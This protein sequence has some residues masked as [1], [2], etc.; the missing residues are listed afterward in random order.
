MPSSPRFITSFHRLIKI[1]STA[2]SSGLGIPPP[3]PTTMA[4]GGIFLHDAQVIV[5]L[6]RF[7]EIVQF[8]ASGSIHIPNLFPLR[9]C[10]TTTTSHLPVT[11]IYAYT[12]QLN[13]IYITQNHV[14]HTKTKY[15]P[16]TTTYK[17]PSNSPPTQT[18]HAFPLVTNLSS[19][20][21]A[22]PTQPP[23]NTHEHPQIPQIPDPPIPD[24]RSRAQRLHVPQHR[25]TFACPHPRPHHPLPRSP[26]AA[27]PPCDTVPVTFRAPVSAPR[28]TMSA[29]R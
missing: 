27:P 16:H 11:E 20:R 17:R 28:T 7:H 22:L 9:I 19:P 12:T 14:K 8:M 10:T 23:T 15:P 26:R 6:Q 3:R 1:Y 21:P 25:T 29:E 4:R 13:T 2:R 5:L 24:P 18:D